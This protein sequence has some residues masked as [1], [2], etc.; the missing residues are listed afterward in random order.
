MRLGFCARP[1]NAILFSQEPR[2]AVGLRWT[3]HNHRTKFQ[4]RREDTFPAQAQVVAWGMGRAQRERAG[5]PVS[6]SSR[7]VAW[8]AERG[9]RASGPRAVFG[10]GPLHGLARG[11]SSARADRGP[12]FIFGPNFAVN[13]NLSQFIFCSEIVYIQNLIL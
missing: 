1:E 10:F 6:V 5:G 2:A 12:F 13:S 11:K 7:M 8:H 9:L 3:T 4:L